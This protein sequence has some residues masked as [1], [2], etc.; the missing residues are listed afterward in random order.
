MQGNEELIDDKIY[1]TL[2]ELSSQQQM[3]V[4]SLDKIELD[5]DLKSENYDSSLEVDENV[6]ILS[7]QGRSNDS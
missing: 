5:R 4:S 6:H 2:C 3:A 1:E 7:D